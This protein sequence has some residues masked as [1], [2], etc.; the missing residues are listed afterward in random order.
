MTAPNVVGPE[1]LALLLHR[2]VST[3][4]TDARRKPDSLL[5][6]WRPP[7]TRKLLWIEEDVINWINA[8]RP[9]VKKRVGRPSGQGAV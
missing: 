8:L 9:Q 3:I 1:Y 6:R 7:G 5:P 4:R 2:K